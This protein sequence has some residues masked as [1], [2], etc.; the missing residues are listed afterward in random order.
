[1]A[2]KKTQSTKHNEPIPTDVAVLLHVLDLPA[3][4]SLQEAV[5]LVGE[6]PKPLKDEQRK[7]ILKTATR[8]RQVANKLSKFAAATAA[9]PEKKRK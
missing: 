3:P 2:K 1:M 9:T 8:L 7:L 6:I 4:K 5:R